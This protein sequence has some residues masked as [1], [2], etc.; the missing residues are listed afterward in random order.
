MNEHGL[1]AFQTLNKTPKF[2]QIQFLRMQI[3]FSHFND[4][5]NQRNLQPQVNF[6]VEQK[7]LSHKQK[8]YLNFEMK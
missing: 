7:T 4:Q 2:K 3:T 8:S 5:K 6:F 1:T